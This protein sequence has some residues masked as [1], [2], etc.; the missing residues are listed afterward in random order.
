MNSCHSTAPTRLDFFNSRSFTSF[1]SC[2]SFSI[3]ARTAS[4]VRPM[5]NKYSGRSPAFIL[6]LCLSFGSK[7]MPLLTMVVCVAASTS[8][9]I[10]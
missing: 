1:F 2:S 7:K 6:W 10:D 4:G 8:F 9:R 5:I 3:A